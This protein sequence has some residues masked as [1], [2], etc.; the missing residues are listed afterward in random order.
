MHG[1]PL[2]PSCTQPCFSMT[3]WA[4]RHWPDCDSPDKLSK[5]QNIA[6]IC[7]AANDASFTLDISCDRYRSVMSHPVNAIGSDDVPIRPSFLIDMARPG[8]LRRICIPGQKFCHRKNHI[9]DQSL[10]Y[11]QQRLGRLSISSIT[12]EYQVLK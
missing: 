6:E 7:R 10:N 4:E 11:F 8:D 1:H 5:C 12:F 3:V 9:K 2:P